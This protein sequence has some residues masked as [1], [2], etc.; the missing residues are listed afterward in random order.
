V[1]EATVTGMSMWLRHRCD[2]VWGTVLDHP[3]IADLA[4][5]T[6][7]LEAFHFYIEQDILFLD[8]YARAIGLAV[9]RAADEDELREL[10]RQLSA[11]VEEEIE[12]ER[13]LL[14]RVEELLNRVPASAPRPAPATQ[15]YSSFL[16]ATA[17]RGDALDVMTALLPCA[18]SYADIGRAHLETTAKHP[19]YTDWMRLFGGEDYLQYVDRRLASYDRFA[20]GIAES[21]RERLL[22]LFL[23]ATRLEVAFWDM[24]YNEED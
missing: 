7:P 6:L 4:A 19:V 2:G 10:T 3:F 14:R 20:A 1:P 18:W 13:V 11:V 16:L 12:K 24:A 21:R 22:E 17:A 8:H 9:G 15:A 23:T 5:G